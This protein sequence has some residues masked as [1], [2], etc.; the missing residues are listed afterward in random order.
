MRREFDPDWYD[1]DDEETV[2]LLQN[3]SLWTLA[4]Y[5]V[6]S[7]IVIINAVVVT[8]RVPLDGIEVGGIPLTQ[9]II[10]GSILLAIAILTVRNLIRRKTWYLITTENICY[11][12]GI[13][14]RPDVDP[15]RLK[16]ISDVGYKQSIF[17]RYVGMGD[18][19]FFTRGGTD[20]VDVTFEDVESPNE[21]KTLVIE[22]QKKAEKRE[23]VEQARVQRK[24]SE[25]DTD[26]F[27]RSGHAANR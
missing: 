9:L 4:P 7:A 3:P 5:A 15:V 23:M 1:F 11:K 6:L 10:A 14:A 21:V 27:D 16:Y 17:D 22:E 2:V 12:R 19:R 18:V 13:F 24:I 26:E 25:M 20:S 8:Q